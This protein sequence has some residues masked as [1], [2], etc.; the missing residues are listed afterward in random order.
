MKEFKKSIVILSLTLIGFVFLG[1]NVN[2]VVADKGLLISGNTTMNEVVYYS[3]QVVSGT[4]VSVESKSVGVLSSGFIR[5]SEREYKDYIE[6]LPEVEVV[7][8]RDLLAEVDS[9]MAQ[10]I[11]LKARVSVL[12]KE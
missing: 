6:S 2:D 11:W 4:V 12:E 5:A 8:V 3:K 1:L 7:A 10:V 9:L